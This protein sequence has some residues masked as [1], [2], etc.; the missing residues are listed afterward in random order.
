MKNLKSNINFNYLYRDA[1]NFKQFGSVI[2]TNP[3]NL[4]IEEVNSI[5]LYKLIDGEYFDHTKFSVPSLFFKDRNADDHNWHEYRNVEMT[6]KN[7][8]DER[9]IEMFLKL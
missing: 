6:D 4:S 1:S 7:P 3:N 8:T 9:T 5:L 2:F